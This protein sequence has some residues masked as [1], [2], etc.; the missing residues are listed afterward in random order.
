MRWEDAHEKLQVILNHEI[1]L[2]YEI[3]SN[4]HQQEH[5]FL[6]GDIE[7]KKMLN[8]ANNQ[9]IQCLKGVIQKRG[10]LT[11]QILDISPSHV[12]GTSLEEELDPSQE[13]EAET[14]LLYQ[15]THSLV[16]KI[17]HEHL[18]LKSLFQMMG[19]EGA[20]EMHHTKLHMEPLSLNKKKKTSLITMD[21]PAD[22]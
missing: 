1:A 6:V 10:A 14:L 20:L 11:R 22:P 19:K 17:H 18:R 2:R 5:V 4:L 9:L 16:D 15:K 21:S 13:L 8:H 7:M 3:L 12:F